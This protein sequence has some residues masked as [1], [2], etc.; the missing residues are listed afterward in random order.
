VS[1]QLPGAAR[2]TISPHFA[3]VDTREARH[4]R[5]STGEG[6]HG[7]D[8]APGE[9]E[10]WQWTERD[11]VLIVDNPQSSARQIRCTLDAR[12]HGARDLS[13][14]AENGETVTPA[15]RIGVERARIEIGPFTVP[16]GRSR[17]VLHSAQPALRAGPEDPRKI[18][19]CVYNV[20]I[21]AGGN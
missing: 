7:I 20:A 2:R 4:L 14:R 5:V 3:L 13:W 15:V 19:V 6:W 12:G 1:L 16:P 10:R 9:P 8:Y 21:T 17:W 11:A 18:A